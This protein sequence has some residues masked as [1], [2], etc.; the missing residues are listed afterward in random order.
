M[1]REIRKKTFF[2][3]ERGWS[4]KAGR[5]SEG[6]GWLPW[7]LQGALHVFQKTEITF[8]WSARG[9]GGGGR[10]GAVRVGTSRRA[11]AAGDDEDLRSG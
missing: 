5:H 9:G 1:C 2:G 10:G 3:S 7:R 6:H 4:F 11:A 8:F